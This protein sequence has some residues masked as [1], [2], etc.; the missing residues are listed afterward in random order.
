MSVKDSKN[1]CNSNYNALNIRMNTYIFNILLA[2]IL[3]SIMIIFFVGTTYN[4]RS[5]LYFEILERQEQALQIT[6]E[7]LSHLKIQVR[8]F[9]I[10][11]L[12]FPA[13]KK[14]QSFISVFLHHLN[15][16]NVNG[17]Y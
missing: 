2:F 13:L 8:S 9:S 3:I 17:T 12:I 16:F 4:E 5:K 14:F 6:Q 15:M 1:N 7:E 10:Q 11:V